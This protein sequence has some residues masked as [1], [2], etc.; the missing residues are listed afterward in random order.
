MIISTLYF[1]NVGDDFFQTRDDHVYSCLTSFGL[2][3]F[4]QSI[5]VRVFLVNVN[6]IF[7]LT[8]NIFFFKFI[9]IFEV[10]FLANIERTTF[11]LIR[12]VF[13]IVVNKIC[14]FF[15]TLL[16]LFCCCCCQPLLFLTQYQLGF[17]QSMSGRIFF[18]KCEL[19]FFD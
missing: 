19:E 17:S 9:S 7:Q 12:L 14:F 16:G 4:F 18:S 10:I 6:D 13:F 3:Y 11:Q 1:D 8:L 2:F 5:L 15:F